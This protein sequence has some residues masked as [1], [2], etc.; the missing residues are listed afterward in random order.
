[1]HKKFF[2]FSDFIHA[3]YTITYPVAKRLIETDEDFLQP[4][5]LSTLDAVTVDI[6]ELA[7]GE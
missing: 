3:A 7:D 5:F 2:N 4:V 1:M 6:G